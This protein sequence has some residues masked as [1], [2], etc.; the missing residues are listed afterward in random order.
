MFMATLYQIFKYKEIPEDFAPYVKFKAAVYK[1]ETINPNDEIA[2][3]D[4]SG[5]TSHHILFLDAYDNIDQIKEELKG[6]D[7][8]ANVNTLKILESHL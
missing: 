7:L 2:I 3:L 6:A 5:T 8:K 1:R 4:V